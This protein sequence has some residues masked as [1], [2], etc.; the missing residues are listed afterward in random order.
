MPHLTSVVDTFPTAVIPHA[1]NGL[2]VEVS[3]IAQLG[4]GAGSHLFYSIAARQRAHA[5]Y[6]D[7]LEEPSAKLGGTNF[8]LGDTTALYSFIVGPQ[9]HPFHRHAGHRI[10]T[11]VSGSGGAQLR[12]SMATTEEMACDPHKF[13]EA[14]HFINIPPDCMFCVRFGGET[15]HQ[16]WPLSK[17]SLHPVFFALSSHTDELG[18]DL[19]DDLKSK[20]KANKA[21][22]PTLT[23]VLPQA[24][25][26]LIHNK[27]FLQQVIPT[28]TLSLDA[29]A[30]TIHHKV[31]DTFRGSMGLMRGFW[32]NRYGPGGYISRADVAKTVVELE[33]V[34][35]HSLLRKQFES[36]DAH[37]QD[38]F[39]VTL[40]GVDFRDLKAHQ[41]LEFLLEGFLN[42]APR[43]V[44]RLML[45]R[46]FLVRPIGLRTSPL[47]CPVSSLLSDDRSNL[48]AGQYPVLDQM[49]AADGSLAQV[50]LGAK[51]KHLIFRSCIGVEMTSQKHVRITLGTS[52]K[53]RNLFGRFYMAAISFVHRKYISP[54]ML[55]RATDYLISKIH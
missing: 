37:H 25:A 33:G 22:I 21:D 54:T 4:H 32:S 48:F 5:E 47:G 18:G 43:G 49:V 2:P 3:L 46:N 6:V 45:I 42:N 16:F 28:T 27:D 34:P 39:M 20:I 50:V 38:T 8:D 12:F 13:L 31:C 52:V 30:G 9:G 15:W 1:R 19:S 14:L 17:N 55:R 11:A 41:I 51:D 24:V 29:P 53:C 44:S 35:A 23:E 26:E 10:F 36:G 40:S 7:A